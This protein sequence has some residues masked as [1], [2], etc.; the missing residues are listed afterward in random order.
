MNVKIARWLESLSNEAMHGDAL[1][2]TEIFFVS[3]FP[4]S[5]S[6][7]LQQT[8][9]LIFSNHIF[10]IYFWDSFQENWVVVK[11]SP[12]TFCFATEQY[13]FPITCFNVGMSLVFPLRENGFEIDVWCVTYRYRFKLSKVKRFTW[14]TSAAISVIC[15]F[16]FGLRNMKLDAS[17]TER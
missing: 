15:K 17:G 12:K 3:F 4:E 13:M 16:W 2:Q 11:L 5:L 10:S 9:Q 14:Y 6:L 8:V 7:L 1:I